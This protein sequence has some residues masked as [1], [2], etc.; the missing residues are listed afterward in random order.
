[1][2]D[3]LVQLLPD[4]IAN[5]IAAGEVI[6][7]PA[8]VVKEL[9][10]NAID[11]GADSIQLILKDSG[12]TLIQIVDDGCGMSET[13]A[14][15]S[16]ERHATSKLRQASDL[17]RLS[18]MGFR[19]EAL[20]S[21]AA[22]AQ[23]EI[24]TRRQADEL[25]TRILV[26]GSE[27]KVQ[28]PVPS[29]PG[30]SMSVRNLF[31]NVPARRNFLKTDGVE[32]RHIKDEFNRLAL[33]HPDVRFQLF[34]ND[35][36][37]IHLPAGK[38]RQRIVKLFGS[39]YNNILIPVE[40]TT[41]VLHITGF[42]GKPEAAKKSRNEQFFFV[43][44]RFIK[45]AYL[46]HALMSAYDDLLSAGQIPFYVIKLDLDPA[47]IDVN[48]HPTKQEIKFADEKLIYNYLKATVRHGLGRA[49]IMPTL[50]FEADNFFS[51]SRTTMRASDDLDVSQELPSKINAEAEAGAISGGGGRRQYDA[52]TTSNESSRHA[53][54]LRH[55]EKLYQGL[56]GEQPT[57]TAD[58][59]FNLGGNEFDHDQG[60]LL[61]S[62]AS[63]DG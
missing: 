7:R 37:D 47:R 5:Q 9:M 45:S 61:P 43:N 17:D 48:V 16:L 21:I 25:G 36:E 60:E 15:M 19:G 32:L 49:S 13:D 63:I 34:H 3:N 24:K 40:E 20:A 58:S 29:A 38:L 46:H 53:S 11:A 52:S 51:P 28:E 2:T 8:S 39:R 54:N 31:Y 27:V 23:L 35:N 44:N 18:T 14:R 33:A 4:A 55:W 57:T 22:V 50:D 30:T 41:D 26:E 10:E 62:R 42:V 59:A 56:G 1:M 12:K 6:Q